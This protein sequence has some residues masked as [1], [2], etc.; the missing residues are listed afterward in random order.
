MYGG[1]GASFQAQY[2][3]SLEPWMPY[4]YALQDTELYTFIVNLNRGQNDS[5][6]CP[7]KESTI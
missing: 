3:K 4:T 7:S 5:M 6:C 2:N 1:Q